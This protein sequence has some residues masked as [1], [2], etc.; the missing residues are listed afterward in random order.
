MSCWHRISST[1]HEDNES[2]GVG[3]LRAGNDQLKAPG[4]GDP[5]SLLPLEV[6]TNTY[7]GGTVVEGA[8]GMEMTSKM[9]AATGAGAA[10]TLGPCF[11]GH[12][13]TMRT[14]H[15]TGGTLK[16]YVVEPVDMTVLGS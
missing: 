3:T 16:D 12:S 13:G 4:E 14:R 6:C 1:D 9:G 2:N 11:L 8:S 15:S 10:G 5:L 7:A